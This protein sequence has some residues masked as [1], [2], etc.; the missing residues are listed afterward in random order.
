MVAALEVAVLAMWAKV[1]TV[2]AAENMAAVE[3]AARVLLAAAVVLSAVMAVLD[4]NGLMEFT[5]PVVERVAVAQQV[6]M[7]GAAIVQA[8]QL[9]TEAAVVA[10]LMTV[11]PPAQVDQ[12]WLLFLT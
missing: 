8:Q 10:V 2:E 12:A 11:A 3:V 5:T 7:A 4:H 9:Q 1:V 6:V